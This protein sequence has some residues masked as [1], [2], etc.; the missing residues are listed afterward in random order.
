MPGVGEVFLEGSPG[1]RAGAPSF[2]VNLH[3]LVVKWRP[4]RAASS[5]LRAVVQCLAATCH[6]L[7]G[8]CMSFRAASSGLRAVVPCLAATCHIL[9]GKCVSFRAASFGLRAAVEFS[10]GILI[11]IEDDGMPPV[12]NAT[13]IEDG[14][15]RSSRC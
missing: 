5:G 15:L 6:I 10:D 11:S 12:E 8:K 1:L 4:F 13:P 2:W 7:V 9:V 3:I 14:D